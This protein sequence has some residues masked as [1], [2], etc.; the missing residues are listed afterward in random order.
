MVL[1]QKKTRPCGCGNSRRGEGSH[2][3]GRG[4]GFRSVCLV[5]QQEISKKRRAHVDV[6]IR[7]GIKETTARDAAW[8]YGVFVWF[9]N[10]KRHAHV[11]V[12]IRVGVKEA[13][14]RDAAWGFG[15][16]VWFSNRKYPKK[17]HAHVDVAIR[18]GVKEA[19]ARDAAWGYG[20]FFWGSP[21]GNT[22]NKKTRPCGC[23][24]SRRGKGNHSKGRGLG[25]RSV[26][27]VLQQ[28]IPS[29]KRHAHVDVAIRVGVR[30]PQQGTRLVVSER[31]FG[32]PTGTNPQQ[33]DTPM[34]M[35][36][37]AQG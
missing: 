24:N 4:L 16:C 35:W 37:F 31:V 11:D 10:R 27:L 25:L 36:Q 5:L 1:Q 32:S 8:G 30:K 28:E 21:T 19:T 14:A 7:V 9:S 18:A 20:G 17:R 15:V 29:T 34:W 12:A 2:S 22:L 13:T 6:A 33:K 26:C 23:G 3:K